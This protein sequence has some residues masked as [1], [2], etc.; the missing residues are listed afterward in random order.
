M[1]VFRQDF[2][3]LNEFMVD[4]I[5]ILHSYRALLRSGRRALKY[6]FPQTETF[7][8]YVRSRITSSDSAPANTALANTVEFVRCA[9]QFEG[10]ENRCLTT[11]VHV[12]HQRLKLGRQAQK[13]PQ[14][15]TELL[16]MIRLNYELY[17]EVRERLN[18]SM[19][20]CL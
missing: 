3:L 19:D 16:E 11:L 6:K 1:T 7:R 8:L 10:L 15:K 9:G 20:L 2:W 13:A 14:K 12:E 17:D 18:G 4:R 5:T